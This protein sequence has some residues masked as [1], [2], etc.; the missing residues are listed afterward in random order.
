HQRLYQGNNL[1][2]I[3]MKAYFQQLT[4]LLLN[5]YEVND[6]VDLTLDMGTLELD[7]DTAV[8]VGLIVNEL[9]T[10]SLKYAFPKEEA[11]HIRI[12]L[13]KEAGD[14]YHLSVKDNGIGKPAA[15]QAASKS[16]GSQLVQL[17]VQQL[18]GS[19]KE[20]NSAGL[21]TEIRFAG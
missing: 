3:E 10:N 20:S 6:R 16:F 21:H 8:P 7:I 12:K 15:P 13:N 4:S 9:V 19:F 17:L 18:D 11:G 1:A 5:G 14:T 2:G